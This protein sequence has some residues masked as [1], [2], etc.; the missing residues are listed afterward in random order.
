[1]DVIRVSTPADVDDDVAAA[2]RD[3][4]FMVVDRL[5]GEDTVEVLRSAYD[6]IIEGR[7]AARGDRLLGDLIRQVKHPSKDHPIFE[8]NAAI[9]AGTDLARRLFGRPRLTK[10]YEMLIDKPAG[11]PHD[12]PWHQDVGYYGRPVAAP[13]ARTDLDD[14]QIWLA[15]DE[16]DVDNGCMQFVSRRQGAPSLAHR[17]ASGDPD[18]E[19]R[20]IEIDEPIDTSAAVACPLQPGGCTV[21]LVGTPH[22]TGPNLSDRSRRAYIFNIGPVKMAEASERALAETWGESARL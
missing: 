22:Y 15:L 20:L 18:D 3:H 17:V 7:V 12:T 1:V 2:F 16:V 11:T 8:R 4:G 21:H 5:V 10:V 9:D 19:G 14:V 6:D 13:G